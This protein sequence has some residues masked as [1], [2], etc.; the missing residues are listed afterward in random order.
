MLNTGVVLRSIL[1]FIFFVSA[2]FSG[3]VSA[4]IYK[5]AD[6]DGRVHYSD[7]KADAG[8]VKAQ[9]V[10]VRLTPNRIPKVTSKLS[11][12]GAST[13]PPANKPKKQET[14]AGKSGEEEVDPRCTLARNIISGRAR[15]R[16]GLP[17]GPHEIEVAQRDIKKFCN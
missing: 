1:P 6:E 8:Q 3:H 11:A 12:P 5:W 7:K 2:I 4:E 15:L 14:L 17:T 13:Q 16:N 9:E 10:D